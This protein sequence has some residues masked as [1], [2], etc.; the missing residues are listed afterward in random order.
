MFTQRFKLKHNPHIYLVL[1][2]E[3]EEEEEDRL[4]KDA[5]RNFAMQQRGEQENSATVKEQPEASGASFVNLSF[6]GENEPSLS[7][8]DPNRVPSPLPSWILTWSSNLS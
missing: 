5:E 8:L 1:L 2:Q 6:E 3:E 4:A 7:H